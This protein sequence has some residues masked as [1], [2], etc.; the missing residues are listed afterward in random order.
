MQRERQRATNRMQRERQRANNRMQRERQRANN[1]MQH[2]R[3]LSRFDTERATRV[4]ATVAVCLLVVALWAVGDKTLDRGLPAG[5]VLQGVVFGSLYALVAIGIV[6]VYRANRVVNFAQA[7]FGSVAA[8]LS[9]EFVLQL[10]MNYFLAVFLGL[11]I[12]TLSGGLLE[13]SVLRRLRNAPRLIVMVLTIGLA[14]VLIG[15][16]T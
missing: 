15:V 9:I 5:I 2:A 10:S 13:M 3:P 16:A 4:A 12:A 11:V 1:R 14:Q 6:L 8:V 7:E